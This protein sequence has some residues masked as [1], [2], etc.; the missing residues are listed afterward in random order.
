MPPL[1]AKMNTTV[2]E[3]YQAFFNMKKWG[4]TTLHTWETPP[5]NKGATSQCILLQVSVI[6][7]YHAP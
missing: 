1:P 2:V 5:G 7:R 4:T 6:R 3:K